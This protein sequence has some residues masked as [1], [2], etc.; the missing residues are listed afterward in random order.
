MEMDKP[1]K[2]CNIQAQPLFFFSPILGVLV[3]TPAETNIPHERNKVSI[4]LTI[5]FIV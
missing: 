3:N 4:Y 1:Q 5:F 2:T